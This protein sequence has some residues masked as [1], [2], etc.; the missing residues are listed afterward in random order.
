MQSFYA[1]HHSQRRGY[2]KNKKDTNAMLIEELNSETK[3]YEN[4]LRYKKRGDCKKV[5]VM[6]TDKDNINS[7][8]ARNGNKLDRRNETQM[9]DLEELLRNY[10]KL[11]IKCKNYM[12][13]PMKG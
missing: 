12:L 2:D 11:A 1:N 9:K 4:R 5:C 3:D 7:T 10:K 8:D 13:K 6:K